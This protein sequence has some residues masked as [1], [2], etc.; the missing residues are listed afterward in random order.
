MK[1]KAQ[2]SLK[3]ETEKGKEIFSAVSPWGTKSILCTQLEDNMKTLLSGGL[4]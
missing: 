2:E 3:E 4:K 1:D